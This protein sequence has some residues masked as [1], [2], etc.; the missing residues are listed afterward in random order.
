V[1]YKLFLQALQ[2]GF[3]QEGLIAVLLG[4]EEYFMSATD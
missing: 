4:S 2:N 1:G 3:T